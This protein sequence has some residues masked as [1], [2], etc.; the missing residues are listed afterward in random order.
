MIPP[1]TI[2]WASAAPGFNPP[3][4]H[5]LLIVQAF[6]NDNVGV[7]FVTHSTDLLRV[8]LPLRRSEL[9]SAFRESGGPLRDED[10]VLALVDDRGRTC[11]AVAEPVGANCLRIGT[12]E[13]TLT[14]VALLPDGE[15]QPLRLRIRAAL[16]LS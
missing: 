15:W 8:G 9:P 6:P 2:G 1:G 10:G 7:A 16:G 14:R 12:S 3:G 4:P 5:P 11:I 13:V